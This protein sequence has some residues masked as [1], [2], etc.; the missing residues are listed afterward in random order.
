MQAAVF[1]TSNPDEAR[2][3]TRQDILLRKAAYLDHGVFDGRLFV[4]PD[5]S[6]IDEDA[7]WAAIEATDFTRVKLKLTHPLFGLGWTQEQA[8]DAELWYKRY[9]FLVAKYPSAKPVPNRHLDEFWH[10]HILDTQAYAE[11]CQRIFGAFHHHYPY[12]GMFEGD[13][14][15]GWAHNVVVTE[16][17]FMVE[18]DVD[19]GDMGAKCNCFGG[20]CKSVTPA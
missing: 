13:D 10:Q 11:D 16:R 18:F 2:L 8:N 4:M 1:Y 9:L 7:V 15:E 6:Q 17:L 19:Y 12:S 20:K 14:F 3:A 5:A